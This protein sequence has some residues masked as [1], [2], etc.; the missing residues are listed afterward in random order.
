MDRSD[1]KIKH[2]EFIQA[3]IN[4]MANTSFLLKGWSI[5]VIAGLF[6]FSARQNEETLLGLAMV[7]TF[8]FWGLDAFFLWQER[9]YRALYEH[10]RLQPHGEID[11][12]MN[13]SRFGAEHWFIAAPFSVT[14][15]PFYGFVACTLTVVLFNKMW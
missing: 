10:V 9:L 13:A 3:V 6:A 11:F 8:V 14:L 2:L 4:R 1:E 12:S 5:T 7:L 15:L